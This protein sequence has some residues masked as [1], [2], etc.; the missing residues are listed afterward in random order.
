MRAWMDG[1]PCLSMGAVGWAPCRR[2]QPRPPRA[3]TTH[4]LTGPWTSSKYKELHNTNNPSAVITCRLVGHA[5]WQPRPA[6]Q[7]YLI[8]RRIAAHVVPT[9]ELGPTPRTGSTAPRP[10]IPVTGTYGLP[11]PSNL[12]KPAAFPALP[13]RLHLT[14]PTPA[15][16]SATANQKTPSPRA[17]KASP[18]CEGEAVMLSTI[19][20]NDTTN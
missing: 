6:Q 13:S 2:R 4:S 11:K 20:T 5:P 8:P 19:A 18:D 7:R 14:S 10:P 15:R 16:H 9:S 17:S 3:A 12:L 1:E